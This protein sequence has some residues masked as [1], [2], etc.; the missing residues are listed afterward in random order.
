MKRPNLKIIVLEGEEGPLK[1]T[2]NIFNK[3]IEEDFPNVKKDMPKKLTEHQI[4]NTK[5]KE[6]VLLPHNN[7]NTKHTE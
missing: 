3:I 6:R 7:Q 4:G 2:E 5:E 1:R